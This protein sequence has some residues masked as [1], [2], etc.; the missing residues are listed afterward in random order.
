MTS[1]PDAPILPS[2]FAGL[3]SAIRTYP[4]ITPRG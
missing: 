4:E 1:E 2:R 3:G